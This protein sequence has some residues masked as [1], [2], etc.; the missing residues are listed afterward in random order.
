MGSGPI[1]STK[2]KWGLTPFFIMERLDKVPWSIR[3]VFK[4]CLGLVFIYLSVNLTGY[5]ILKLNRNIRYIVNIISSLCMYG[6]GIWFIVY[7]LKVNYQSSLSSIGIRWYKWLKGSFKGILFYLG[8]I[9]ILL[10]L[11][12][13]GLIFCY[14]LG[15]TPQPHPLVEILKKEK[16]LLFI[17][18]LVITAIVIAPVFEEILFRGL[19]YQALKRHLGYIRAAVIS[20]GLFSLMHFNPSQF[21]PVL[22]LGML[23]CFIFE[24]TGSL[25][26]VIVL[27]IFNNGLFLGLFF[28][29][30]EH[31]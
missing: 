6:F 5:L 10:I 7:F 25:V 11:T 19:F 18:H 22:G 8:F 24:Y 30:K 29:L 14:I 12:Y 21:L 4:I 31:I 28:I 20:S 27:H 26:P 3:D 9:P 15:I 13:I 2:K 16:S 17:Y 1:F 23:L